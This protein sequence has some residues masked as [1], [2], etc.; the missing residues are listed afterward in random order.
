MRMSKL[1]APT[2]RE[3]PKEAEVV[4]HKLMLRAGYIKKL[5]AGVYEFL[6]LGVRTLHKVQ[7]IIRQEMN[8]AGAQE[9]FL[10]T[11]LP[12]EL[13]QETGRWGIYGKELFRITDRHEREFC[14]G[15][16]H[17]EIVTDLARREIRSDRELP[18]TLYQVQVKFRDEPR[19]F[20]CAI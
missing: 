3:D 10:P 4:S 18:K 6:P 17:E 5:A 12:A 16:T 9:V 14:L 1:L 19:P 2:L 20:L 11:L 8:R 7:N 15:P 13:W